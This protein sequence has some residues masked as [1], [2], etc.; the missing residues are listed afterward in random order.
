MHAWQEREQIRLRA[1]LTTDTYVKDGAV[2]WRSNDAPVPTSTFRDAGLPVP[3]AQEAARDRYLEPILREYREAMAQR[4]PEQVAEQR[5]EA[6]AAM[7]TGVEMVNVL[8]GEKYT[9]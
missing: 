9:T 8:T 3:P 4:T 5:A 7:G 6:R 1:S 2:I